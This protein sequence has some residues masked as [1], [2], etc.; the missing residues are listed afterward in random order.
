MKITIQGNLENIDRNILLQAFQRILEVKTSTTIEGKNH[1]LK[2]T[3]SKKNIT[4][5]INSIEKN[6]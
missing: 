3:I 6:H 2:I 1:T 5:L 4:C